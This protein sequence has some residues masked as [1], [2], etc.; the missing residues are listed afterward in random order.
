MFLKPWTVYH[1]LKE[2]SFQRLIISGDPIPLNPPSPPR[3]RGKKKK[4]GLP[5]LLDT[6]EIAD[7]K[8]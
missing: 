1:K 2:L 6:P 8:H 3:G 5:P 4:E 7:D